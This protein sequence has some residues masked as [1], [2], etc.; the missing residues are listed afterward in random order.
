MI[1]PITDEDL[2]QLDQL[3][4]KYPERRSAL[5]PMLHYVQAVQGQVSPAG[6]L[7]CAKVLDLTPA[8]V[9]AV[10]TFYTMFKRFPLGKHHIG[11]CTNSL[12]A[13]LG[14]DELWRELS[15][16]LGVGHDET[17]E[18]KMFTLERIE[19]QAACT[20]APVITVNWE[21]F[22]NMNPSKV[23]DLIQKLK[24]G[25]PVQS[26]RGALITSI[27]DTERVLAGINDGKSEESEAID[28]AML[29]GL[30]VAKARGMT[31]P[32]GEGF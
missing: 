28:E 21:F 29:A 23:K 17:T 14:G 24:T 25:A 12:C 6:I 8:E 13:I 16:T 27:A 9:A 5:L 18:D 30:K 11:V 1:A 22:D 3:A 31:A 15:E 4:K 19:C 32:K 7:A 26:T 10:A 20:M 2:K